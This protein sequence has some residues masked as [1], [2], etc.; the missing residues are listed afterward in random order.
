MAENCL[1]NK[2]IFQCIQ[3]DMG[4]EMSGREKKRVYKEKK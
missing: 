4:R 2:I 1:K 3:N